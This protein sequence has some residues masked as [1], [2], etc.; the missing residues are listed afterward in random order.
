MAMPAF[1]RP[2]LGACDTIR[3]Q[4]ESAGL[5]VE[6]E[7]TRDARK[8]CPDF[9]SRLVLFGLFIGRRTRPRK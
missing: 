3:H 7:K 2:I 8:V 1:W 6:T 5:I 4:K 9:P